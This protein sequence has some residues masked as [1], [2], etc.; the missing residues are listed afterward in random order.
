MV[1]RTRHDG[2]VQRAHLERSVHVTTTPVDG[3]IMPVA[4][5]DDDFSVA[6]FYKF[7]PARSDLIRLRD[8]EEHPWPFENRRTVFEGGDR[9][10]SRPC[11]RT[12][13]TST[14]SCSR[15]VPDGTECTGTRSSCS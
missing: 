14:V 10:R 11:E 15:S 2:A 4:I 5:A 13:R 12:A 3:V 7:H 1:H 6:C 9:G 8:F